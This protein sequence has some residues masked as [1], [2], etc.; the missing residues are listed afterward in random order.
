MKKRLSALLLGSVL[1]L[2]LV[3]CNNAKT[4][5]DKTSES[6]APQSVVTSSAA[7]NAY[8]EYVQATVDISDQKMSESKVDLSDPQAYVITNEQELV[9]FEEKYRNTY[10]LNEVDSGQTFADA[11]LDYNAEF[12]AQRALVVLVVKY[13]PKTEASTGII[14]ASGSE[15]KIDL[16][17]KQPKETEQA[18]YTCMLLSIP[19]TGFGMSDSPTV[20]INHINSEEIVE[21]TEETEDGDMEIVSEGEA[22]EESVQSSSVESTA[23]SS[24]SSAKT[25]KQG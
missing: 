19:K 2:S 8:I 13:V 6:N 9:D 25:S 17:A 20:R 23:K 5:S 18:S 21:D 24:Q 22:S 14:T 7:D 11:E 16:Y 12:F 15:L 4:Q 10:S 3:G 1:A